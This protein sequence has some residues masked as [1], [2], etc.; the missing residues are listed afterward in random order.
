M[1]NI[2]LLFFSLVLIACGKSEKSNETV[3]EEVKNT[4]EIVVSKQQ[5]EGEKMLLG[6]LTKHSFNKTVKT[7]GLIDVPPQNRASISTF[8]S[9]YVKKTPLLIGDKV[10]K[11][12]LIAI[13]ENTEF[14]EIQQ[15]YLEIAEQLHYLKSEFERQETL[16]TEKITSQKN[17]IKAKS[18]YKSSLATYNGLRKKLQMMNINPVSVEKGNMSSTINIY[19]PIDG[20]VTKVYASN[21]EFVSSSNPIVEIINTDHIHLELSV[22]EKDILK[23]KKGQEIIFKVPETSNKVFNAEVHLVGT[24][25]NEKD[26]TI[27]V[28]GHINDDEKTNFVTGMFVEANLIINAKKG[29]ALPKDAVVESGGNYF[30]LVLNN[31]KEDNYTFKKVKL[32]VGEKNESFIEVLNNKDFEGKKILVKGI[33]MLS[34]DN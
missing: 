6:K 4:N 19:T 23:I 24:S 25:V 15:H 31:Q 3:T 1:K 26:R 12:Q 5:F 27:K 21:G 17:F 10:K 34:T 28:H 9:G 18:T 11:G 20:F 2:Y 8:I 7:S 22:F 33:F 30:T 29:Q 14:I 16:Y 13:L 32:E